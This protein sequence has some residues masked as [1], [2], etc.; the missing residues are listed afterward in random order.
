MSPIRRTR[1]S[2]SRAVAWATAALLGCGTAAHAQTG[3]A[4][5]R[6]AGTFVETTAPAAFGSYPPAE[7]APDASAPGR[8]ANDR[9]SDPNSSGS[10]ATPALP[11]V[12]PSRAVEP[13]PGA[14]AVAS[15]TGSGP[16]YPGQVRQ[17]PFRYSFSVGSGYDTAV[18]DIPHLSGALTQGEG[19]I[20]VLLHNRRFNLL[21]QH[22]ALLTRSFK[23][24][25]GLEQYQRTSAAFIGSPSRRL[26]WS[27][28][29]ENGYGADA[30]RATG[31]LSTSVSNTV[32]VPD[33]N[34]T[35]FGLTDGN[36]LSDHA[37]FGLERR[38]SPA[39]TF[40]LSA[41]TYYHY[42]LSN[43]L[44]NQQYSLTAGVRQRWSTREI[45]GLQGEAVQENYTG[46]DCTTGSAELYS[47]TQLTHAV[48]FE[49][50]AGPVFGSANCS[51]TYEYNVSLAADIGHSGQAYVGSARQRNDGLVWQATWE[52]STFGGFTFGQPRRL[53][54]R[55]DAGYADYVLAT[56]TPADP[57][58]HGYFF[59]GELHHRLSAAAELSFRARYFYRGPSAFDTVPGETSTSPSGLKLNRGIF[60]I[61]YSWSSQ[62]RP[63]RLRA[64]ARDRQT[65]NGAASRTLEAASGNR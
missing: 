60:L 7:N 18:N 49:G 30:A 51:G 45:V 58:L 11:S 28:L 20:G 13:L 10:S 14:G 56:P 38:L 17:Q 5:Q 23:T 48:H 43:G 52:T 65:D 37:L 41:G 25:I 4:L 36:I 24:G 64:H 32:A 34:A 53:Q 19:Y 1:E 21:L 15:L 62:D 6:I 31:S 54:T 50:T 57:D 3:S 2:R 8:S 46:V 59:A 42:F 39:R 55:F 63:T 61:T 40:D 26:S 9:T 35:V 22:D 27:F 47:F 33:Q 44:S 16:F 12:P 29:L